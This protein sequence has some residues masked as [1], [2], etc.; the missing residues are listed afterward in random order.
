M[1]IIV[2]RKSEVQSGMDRVRWA[3]G[4]IEQLPE[5]HDGRN[6]WLLNYHQSKTVGDYM[7]LPDAPQAK[8]APAPAPAQEAPLFLDHRG[9][10]GL[11]ALYVGYAMEELEILQSCIRDLGDLSRV[12]ASIVAGAIQ[13]EIRRLIQEE[14]AWQ[15]AAWRTVALLPSPAED[16]AEV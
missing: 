2:L 13:A 11:H 5:N 16:E 1:K 7:T 15:E 4:L 12:N 10:P 6:S 14:A 8:E 3:Q 9:N